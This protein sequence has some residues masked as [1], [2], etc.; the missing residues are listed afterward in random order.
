MLKCLL[1]LFF[2]TNCFA[3]SNL[4]LLFP[5]FDYGRV[6][7]SNTYDDDLFVVILWEEE[8]DPNADCIIVETYHD[9]EICYGKTGERVKYF[10]D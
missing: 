3:Y 4:P 7:D 6:M 8:E 9:K 2:T 5:P 1:F 10:N